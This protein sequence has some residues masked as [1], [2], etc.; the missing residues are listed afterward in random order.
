MTTTIDTTDHTT[1]D[2]ELID[3]D[4]HNRPADI[5]NAFAASVVQHGV[6]M[7]IAVTAADGRY[8]LIAGERHVEASRCRRQRI[9]ALESARV[10]RA[11]SARP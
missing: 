1:I 3:R 9:G 8:G 11:K 2:L 10:L 7:P 5:D 6:L 4:E